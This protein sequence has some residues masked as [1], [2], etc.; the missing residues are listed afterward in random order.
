ML[1]T[2]NV[3]RFKPWLPIFVKLACKSAS[4][5][6]TKTCKTTF[7]TFRAARVIYWNEKT[8]VHLHK[9]RVREVFLGLPLTRQHLTRNDAKNIRLLMCQICLAI[10]DVTSALVSWARSNK[11][12]QTWEDMLRDPNIS[13][14]L[15]ILTKWSC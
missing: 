15:K 2:A 9:K 14:K 4:L 7:G 3:P 6:F 11:G 13:K 8:W 5:I 10:F 1:F 12:K